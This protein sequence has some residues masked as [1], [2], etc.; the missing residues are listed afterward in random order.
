MKMAD[1]NASLLPVCI[2][3]K[4]LTVNCDSPSSTGQI[5]DDHPRSASYDLQTQTVPPL[6][7]EFLR[8][9]RSRTAVPYGSYFVIHYDAEFYIP[10]DVYCVAYLLSF[11]R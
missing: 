1:F 3:I 7:N 9:T 5:F 8:L 11:H 2:L 6:A 4:R 10:I